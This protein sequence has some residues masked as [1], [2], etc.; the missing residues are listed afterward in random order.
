[1]LKDCQWPHGPARRAEKLMPDVSIIIPVY[2]RV[3]LLIQTLLSCAFQTYREL[4]VIVV[5][6]GS[7]E[8]VESAIER[9]QERCEAPCR[10]RYLH[11]PRSGANAA[12]NKG[13][14]EAVGRFVQF[15]DSDDLLHPD[16]IRVQRDFLLSNSAVDMVFSLD[17]YFHH[18]PGDAQV[19]W[20][21]PDVPNYL[22]RFLWDDGVWHTG[23]PLWR[24]EAL[25]R[26]GPWD[27][28]L[29]CYQDWEF[30]IR[31]LCRGIRHAALP[32]ILQFIRDHEQTRISTSSPIRERE[33]SKLAAVIA[34]AG[35]LT[36]ASAWSAQRGDALGVFLIQIAC[37][38]SRAGALRIPGGALARAIWYAGSPKLRLAALL[39]LAVLPFSR[40]Y[41]CGRGNALETVRQ[42][43]QR[44]RALPVHNSYWKTLNSSHSE[45]LQGLV[46]AI[47]SLSASAGISVASGS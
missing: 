40:A 32:R 12:R 1:M 27:E 8:D 17:Q 9:M 35:E 6:D 29:R 5:D 33:Q 39:M 24:R 28:R 26:V 2:N 43:A 38:L 14:R 37:S 41:R 45:P 16:K 47:V 21:T 13:L 19:L 15:L 20:N 44:F 30:H 31:A 36:R 34:V 10:F 7:D 42:L 3:D 22:D 23:S 4:E 46:H 18:V 25:D 11:Q